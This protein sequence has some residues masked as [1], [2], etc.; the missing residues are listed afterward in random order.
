MTRSALACLCAA[1]L[2]VL[3]ASAQE[4]KAVPASRPGRQLIARG[5]AVM[6]SLESGVF[7]PILD[8]MHHP[9]G[10]ADTEIAEDRRAIS[11]ALQFLSARFGKLESYELRSEPVECLCI[12]LAM[13][14]D[15][16][17]AQVPES[18]RGG[19]VAFTSRYAK[20]QS[21]IVRITETNRGGGWIRSLEFGVP[22]TLPGAKDQITRIT[23]DMISRMQAVTRKPK[24]STP[25][26]P[27]RK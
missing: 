12:S 15:E 9:P 1:G 8:Q 13:G 18:D 14:P 4:P 3:A 27:Q 7:S 23:R 11:A 25:P 19:A 21:A 2:V 5:T 26:E 24:S 6:A 20:M 17:W 22:P 16:Y 10:Y